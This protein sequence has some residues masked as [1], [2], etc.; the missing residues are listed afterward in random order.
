MEDRSGKTDGIEHRAAADREREGLPVDMP[1][2]QIAQHLLHTIV[3]I[4]HGFATGDDDNVAGDFHMRA[5]VL[6]ITRDK[7]AQVRHREA[8]AIVDEYR[9]AL[10]LIGL[11][12]PERLDQTRVVE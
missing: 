12:A 6:R 11:E 4:L 9:G 8:D 3:L 1:R 2:R 10:A 5:V 7:P